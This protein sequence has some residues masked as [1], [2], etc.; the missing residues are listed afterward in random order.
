MLELELEP[1]HVGVEHADGLLE[2]L[3]AGLVALEDDDLQGV[4]HGPDRLL[5][6]AAGSSAVERRARRRAPRARR[7]RTRRARRS[8]RRA[9]RR[10]SR[11][12]SRSTAAANAGVF[13]FFL[14]D[15]GVM[16][17]DALRAARRR[18]PCRSRDSSSTAYSVFSIG[19]SRETP[20]EVGVRG[21]R[22]HDAPGEAAALELRQRACAGGRSSRSGI[23]LVVEVVQQP[24]E[25]PQLLVLAELRARRRASRPRRRARAGAAIRTAVHS[26]KRVQASSRESGSGHGCYPSPRPTR[27]RRTL[28]YGEVRHR[29]RR[30]AVRHDRAR[31]Q[32]ER[33]AADP[34]RVPA[35]RRGGRRCATSRGSATSR[36]CSRC[37]R[38][39]GVD[40][41]SGA[42]TTTVA[43]CAADVD[44]RPRSTAELAERIRASFLLAGP[45]LARFGARRDA[46]AGRRRDRPPPAGPAPRRLPRARRRR[47]AR[48]RHRASPRPTAACAPAT[49]SWTSRR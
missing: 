16:P 1:E 46:A 26:Q 40:A 22:A 31:R 7:S 30:A 44:A 42:A 9:P 37:S 21:D 33:R 38:D 4:R 8:R 17:V 12:S 15:F 48:P 2:Q 49:S 11:R 35:H 10:P 13:I 32:Q 28:R 14:T 27:R 45:L 23:A 19:E 34:R 25:A 47:R 29:R 5:S 6:V 3:L 39:L 36:R 24:D 18:R 41:S 20:E 43:L